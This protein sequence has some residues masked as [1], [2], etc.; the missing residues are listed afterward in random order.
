MNDDMVLLGLKRNM[1]IE[2]FEKNT[3][4]SIKELESDYSKVKNE[5]IR[6]EIRKELF[7]CKQFLED[8][9]RYKEMYGADE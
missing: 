1:S 8:I 6:S 3:L 2:I 4:T 9:Q 7:L 5:R